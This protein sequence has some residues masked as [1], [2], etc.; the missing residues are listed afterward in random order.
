MRTGLQEEQR[1]LHVVLLPRHQPVRLDVA[2]PYTLKFARQF[3]RTVLCR[4]RAVGFEQSYCIIEKLQI[5]P[6]LQA[7]FQL[8]V[9]ALGC[10]NTIHCGYG[11]C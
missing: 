6:S 10:I 8:F 2:L 7:A 4:Q 5:K 9:E 1:Q 11:F 3:V